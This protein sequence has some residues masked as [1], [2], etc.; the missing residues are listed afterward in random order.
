VNGF[1]NDKAEYVIACGKALLRPDLKKFI[2]LHYSIWKEDGIWQRSVN[3][4]LSTEMLARDQ[5]VKAYRCVGQANVNLA[6]NNTR[7]LFALYV[8]ASTEIRFCS[9]FKVEK[10]RGVPQRGKSGVSHATY[11]KE[12]CLQLIY[13]MEWNMLSTEEKKRETR[14][15]QKRL[16]AGKILVTFVESFSIGFLLICWPKIG[17]MY[18]AYL[19]TSTW[20]QTSC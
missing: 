19:Y 2:A 9:E 1:S 5:L 6:S 12:K 20:M 15:L 11:E 17:D 18:S 16:R 8:L 13:G 14:Q 4:S 7:L 10:V 3:A